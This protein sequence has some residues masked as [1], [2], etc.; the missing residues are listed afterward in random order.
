MTRFWATIYYI[1]G[2]T[3]YRGIAQSTR[4]SAEPMVFG[5]VIALAWAGVAIRL[6]YEATKP[7][8]SLLIPYDAHYKALMVFCYLEA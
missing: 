5:L 1:V 2:A 6:T 3:F 8:Q 4:V 7:G